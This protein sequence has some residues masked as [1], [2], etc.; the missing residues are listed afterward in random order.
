MEHNLTSSD[1]IIARVMRDFRVNNINWKASGYDWIADAM[2]SI[3]AWFSF[4]TKTKSIPIFEHKG[5]YPCDLI[6]LI[7]VRYKGLKLP[8]GKNIGRIP[9]QKLFDCHDVMM[10]IT[11]YEKVKE[12]NYKIQQLADLQAQY[13]ST[14]DQDVLDH[15][16]EI[17]KQ[18]SNYT[19][20]YAVSGYNNH[21]LHYYNLKPGA[22]ETTFDFGEVELIYTGATSDENGFPLIPDVYEFKEAI[23][24][25]IISRLLLGGYEHPTI[26]WQMADQKWERLRVAARNKLKMPSIDR[27]QA[28][29]NMWTSPVFDRYLGNNFF[30][31]AQNINHVTDETYTWQGNR[32][33]RN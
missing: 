15:I 29:A 8:L 4:E 14:H 10:D 6:E 23:A 25:Y 16:V 32:Q 27:M 33:W 5:E 12:V 31:G 20:P 9:C 28:L 18:I 30:E 1:E 19:I 26:N 24:W 11:N 17:T 13:D 3:N 7:G 21:G 22:I 2:S